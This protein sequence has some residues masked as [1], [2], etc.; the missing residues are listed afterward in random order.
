MTTYEPTEA[1]MHAA[2]DLL[3]CER[4]EHHEREYCAVVHH[5]DE[6]WYHAAWVLD[7][8]SFARKLARAVLAAATPSIQA[9]AILDA[10]AALILD[11]ESEL[12]CREHGSAWPAEFMIRRAAEIRGGDD[13]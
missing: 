4:V 11:R 9:G 1:V 2:M 3:G 12:G 10:A 5:E 13:A 8:C 7:G 6:P